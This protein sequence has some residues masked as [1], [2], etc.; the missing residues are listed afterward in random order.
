MQCPGCVFQQRPELLLHLKILVTTPW[1]PWKCVQAAIKCISCPNISKQ[2][3]A[4][5]KTY[6][7]NET[8]QKTLS[9]ATLEQA[10]PFEQQHLLPGL[11]PNSRMG[12]LLTLKVFWHCQ[13]GPVGA[14]NAFK[15]RSCQFIAPPFAPCMIEIT[16]IELF[17]LCQSSSHV[18]NFFYWSKTMSSS[19][20]GHFA[21]ICPLWRKILNCI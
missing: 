13:L 5:Q 9:S 19:W 1:E 4:N 10:L 6:K 8:N 11:F 18:S 14:K 20:Y 21:L 17:C 15:E 7:N 16:L 2:A 12:A 3:E